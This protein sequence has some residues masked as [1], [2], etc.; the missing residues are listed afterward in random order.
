MKRKTTSYRIGYQDGYER[1]VK[2]AMKRLESAQE[3][4]FNAMWLADFYSRM[5]QKAVEQLHDA[6]AALSAQPGAQK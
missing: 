5:L 1:G 6:A 2:A 4:R 3:E